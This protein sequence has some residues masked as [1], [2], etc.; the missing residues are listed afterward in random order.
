MRVK[1]WMGV[2]KIGGGQW[3]MK[4]DGRLGQAVGD[5]GGRAVGAGYCSPLAASFVPLQLSANFD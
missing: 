2:Y 3:G 5:E 4:A 1:Y